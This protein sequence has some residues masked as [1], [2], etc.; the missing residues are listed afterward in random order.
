MINTLRE[1]IAINSAYDETTVSDDAPYGEGAK[2]ALDW[3]VAKAKSLGLKTGVVGN[4]CA[5]AEAGE[6]DKMVAGLCHLDVVP[7]GDGWTTPPFELFQDGG[8]LYGRGVTDDKGPLVATLFALA[9]AAKKPLKKRIRLIVGCDE[10]RGSSCMKYYVKHAEI[11]EM[12]FVPDANFPVINCEKNIIQLDLDFKVRSSLKDD[13]SFISA[14]TCYNAVPSVAKVGIKK[15]SETIAKLKELN[16]GKI[17]SDL[18]S[19]PPIVNNIITDGH[20]VKQFSVYETD[21]DFVFETSGTAAHASIPEEGD[22]AIWKLLCLLEGVE[23]LTSGETFTLLNNTFCTTLAQNKLGIDICDEK[24]GE[25]TMSCDMLNYQNGTLKMGVDIR[26]PLTITKDEIIKKLE[27]ANAKATVVNTAPCLYVP[28]ESPLVS[29]L[30]DIYKTAFNDPDA[31]PLI[32]GGGTYAKEIPNAVAF[33]PVL[34]Y[35]SNEHSIDEC[36]P[37]ELFF[38]LAEVYERAYLRLAN[39]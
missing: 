2:R 29:T 17:N 7:S 25:L 34:N 19:L 8:K 6:G 13:L 1:I 31:K 32:M 14:G 5:Y 22:N 28:E 23:S 38:K 11:P 35:E 3:F 21:E 4:R 16:G 9:S 15:N 33:G 39:D 12:S 20:E 27:D 26:Y 37:T 36:M 24:T 18:F 30:M 10:E